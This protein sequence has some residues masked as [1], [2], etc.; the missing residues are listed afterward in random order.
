MI[1]GVVNVHLEATL[2]LTLRGPNGQIRRVTAMVDTGFNGSLTLPRAIIADLGLP[3]Q[4][5]GCAI[6]A[7][8]SESVF[9]IY[10][11]TVV[12]DQR[13]REIP[14]GQVDATPLVGTALLAKYKLSAEFQPR[15]EVTIARLR[16]R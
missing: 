3:W 6:L 5:R 13:R 15:G 8:G 16:Q 14:V 1:T 11:G 2:R 9:E 4:Q 10:V 7:N 12:W